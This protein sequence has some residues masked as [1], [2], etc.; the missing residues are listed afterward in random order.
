MKISRSQKR[1]LKESLRSVP[2]DKRLKKP[3]MVWNVNKGDLVEIKENLHGIVIDLASG[4]HF[5]VLSSAG[6]S[7]YHGSKLVKIQDSL[8]T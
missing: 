5:L 6:R 2:K 7:W 8:S 3:K 1:Q 4:G